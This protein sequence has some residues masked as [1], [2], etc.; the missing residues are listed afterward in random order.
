MSYLVC[1]YNVYS[2]GHP[3][4]RG[5]MSPPNSPRKYSKRAPSVLVRTATTLISWEEQRVIFFN[6]KTYIWDV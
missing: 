2:G 1:M 5:E 6:F 3:D 4:C